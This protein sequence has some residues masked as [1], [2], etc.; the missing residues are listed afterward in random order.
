MVHS[1]I[2]IETRVFPA[3]ITRTTYTL[4]KENIFD[5][6]ANSCRTDKRIQ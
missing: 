6:G 2:D 1:I 4:S 3:L 5:L